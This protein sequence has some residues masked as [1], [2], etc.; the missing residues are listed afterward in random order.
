M[1]QTTNQNRYFYPLTLWL[2]KVA[3]GKVLNSPASIS[4][5]INNKTLPDHCQPFPKISIYGFVSCI[6]STIV[7]QFTYSIYLYNLYPHFLEFPACPS[8]FCGPVSVSTHP[9][10]SPPAT[11]NI[12]EL[13]RPVA[14]RPWHAAGRGSRGSATPKH[15]SSSAPRLRRLQLGT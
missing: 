5:I 13:P 10:G 14:A 11:V 6:F 2:F 3:T 4:C 1:F 8:Q 7:L 15:R 12:S 9:R